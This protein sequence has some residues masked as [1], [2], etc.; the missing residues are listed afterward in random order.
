MPDKTDNSILPPESPKDLKPNNALG[1]MFVLLCCALTGIGFWLS[2]GPHI[3]MW[4][5]G[6]T[7]LAVALLQWFILLHEAGHGTLF[8]GRKRNLLLG[9]VASFFVGIPFFSWRQV[10]N[11]HHMWTGWQDRDPTTASLV[12]RKLSSLEKGIVNCCWKYWIPLFGILYRIQNFWNIPRLEKFITSR[13]TIILM[14]L[15]SL[16]VLLAYGLVFVLV[17]PGLILKYFGLAFLLSLIMQE[18]LLLSQH[19]HIPMELS[20]GNRVQPHSSRLQEKFTRTLIFPNWISRWILMSFD[21][22]GKH[23]MYVNTP[24]YLLN[25]ISHKTEN[26]YAGFSWIREARKIPG[27]V[28][29][30]KNRNQSMKNL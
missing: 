21:L 29:L 19:T 13:H 4:L 22:H 1:L 8:K 7:V 2:T 10:H 9:H 23:H 20:C 18:T 16:G 5:C 3:W 15:N 6:Q 25:G 27:E 17:G 26:Q 28:F 30:F 12:P 14:S 24:G 11:L